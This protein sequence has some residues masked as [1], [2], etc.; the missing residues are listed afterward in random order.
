MLVYDQHTQK[1]AYAVESG[2]RGIT[3][4]GRL[5]GSAKYAFK[6]WAVSVQKLQVNGRLALCKSSFG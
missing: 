4:V 3:Q 5:S 2:I 6:E 1:A